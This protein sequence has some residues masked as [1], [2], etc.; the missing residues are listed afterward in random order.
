LSITETSPHVDTL[1]RKDFLHEFRNDYSDGQ[2]VTLLGPT[3]RGK[4]TLGGQML[5]VVVSPE[6]KA[7]ILHGKIKGRDRTIPKLAEAGNFRIISAWPPGKLTGRN[8][9][10]YILRPLDKP[11]ETQAEEN[12]LLHDEFQKA[13]RAN[14]HT[15]SKKPRITVI[16]ESHQAQH[17]L[18]LKSDIEG[19]LMR[20]AP[21]NACWNFVQRGRFVSYHCYDAAEHLIIFYDSDDSNQQRYAEIGDV[22]PHEILAITA[23]LKRE[24]VA[25][26][27]TIS[28]ALYIRRGGGMYIVDT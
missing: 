26:G 2:H 15:S 10:G 11:G 3:G 27:R 1:S 8:G 19:P 5:V 20:G 28:Q 14:Y 6:R 9:N 17:D 4:T 21:D 22:D 18:K 25:D 24:R 23:N 13:I 12:Q 16:D 7:V